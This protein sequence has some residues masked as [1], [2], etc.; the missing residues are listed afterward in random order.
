VFSARCA[1]VKVV[2][3]VP[4]GRR[5]AIRR[6]DIPPRHSPAPGS[7]RWRGWLCCRSDVRLAVAQERGLGESAPLGGGAKLGRAAPA[8][9]GARHLRLGR[10]QSP[11]SSSA[12]SCGA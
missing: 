12:A 3:E 11:S 8:E 1:G 4:W 5:C 10:P 6:Q 2:S 9:D 7:R